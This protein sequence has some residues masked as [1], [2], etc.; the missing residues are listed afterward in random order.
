MAYRPPKIESGPGG[1]AKLRDLKGRTLAITMDL[2]WAVLQRACPWQP[3][4]VH[5]VTDMNLATLEAL[6]KS[7]PP[8]VVVVAV[9]GGSCCDTAKYLAWKRG[10]RLIL[11]PTIISVDAPL[12]NMIAV[13]VDNAVKYVGDRYPEELIVDHALIQ[14]APPELNRAG[15]ADIASIHTALYDWKLAHEIRGEAYDSEV[16][17]LANACLTELDRNATEVHDV[18][19]KGIDTIVDLYRREVE[20]CARINT[21]RP[22]EGSEH[23]IAYNLEHITRRHFVH[24]DL[25]ALGIFLM[26]RLQENQHAWAVE[27]MDRLGLRYVVPGVTPDEVRSCLATLKTFTHQNHLF[28][29]VVDTRDITPPFIN[30]ALKA[31]YPS[32]RSD[33]S[34][35]SDVDAA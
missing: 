8:C 2:P 10:C 15:A 6:E 35:R 19:A 20:F 16:A 11:V 12:T 34:D 3:D 21:S 22:E 32:D 30:E 13:R 24:G 23:L 27:L 29:S 31:L 9:G 25:V 14:Q 17:A 33:R 5:T 1:A 4:H 28:F 7:L 26:T 18:T